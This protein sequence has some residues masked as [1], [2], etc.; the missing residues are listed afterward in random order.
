M[1]G[2]GAH[3]RQGTEQEGRAAAAATTGNSE[4]GASLRYRAQRWTGVHFELLKVSLEA[5]GMT[6]HSSEDQE[7]EGRWG[8]GKVQER[9]AAGLCCWCCSNWGVRSAVLRYCG[10]AVAGSR[11]AVWRP[12]V[13]T[14]PVPDGEWQ[15][16][17]PKG[18]AAPSQAYRG[19]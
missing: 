7:G 18:R 4:P 6:G 1:G 10:T 19:T 9:W 3:L 11:L 5:D 8:R 13:P 15:W 12:D 16:P 14:T 2:R 17:P